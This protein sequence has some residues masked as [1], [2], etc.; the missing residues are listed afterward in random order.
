M[1]LEALQPTPNV[2]VDKCLRN[3]IW[4]YLDQELYETAAFTAE[5][6]YAL[7]NENDSTRHLIGIIN[8]RMGRFLTTIEYTENRIHLGCLYIHALSCYKIKK[9]NIGIAALE[10]AKKL[11]DRLVYEDPIQGSKYR[12]RMPTS[13]MMYL[14]LGKLYRVVNSEKKA[15]LNFGKALNLDPLCWEASAALCEL[16]VT[17]DVTSLYT[18][19]STN[20]FDDEVK[21]TQVQVESHILAAADTNPTRSRQASKESQNSDSMDLD[22]GIQDFQTPT[23]GKKSFIDLFPDPSAPIKSKLEQK[24]DISFQDHHIVLPSPRLFEVDH[25]RKSSVE[26]STPSR[27]G[28]FLHKRLFNSSHKVESQKLVRVATKGISTNQKL[29]AYKYV[30]HLYKIFIRCYTH[31]CKYQC[32]DAVRMLSCLGAEQENTP[33]VLS[34][35]A[36]IYFEKVE[37]EKAAEYYKKLLSVDRYRQEDMEYYSTLLWHLKRDVELSYLA[38]SL[39]NYNKSSPQAWCAVGNALSLMRDNENALKAFKR[40]SSLQ[41]D[42]PY[43]YTLQAHEHVASDAHE[44]AQNCYREALNVDKRHYN[45]WYGLGMVCIRLGNYEHARLHF[46]RAS[47]INPANVVLICCIGMVH[48]KLEQFGQ[49]LEQYNK[50]ISL[51]PLSALARFKR[52]KLS[53]KMMRFDDAMYDLDKL[54]VLTPDEATV[55]FLRGQILKILGKKVAAVQE[56]TVA[57]SLDP[58]S[59]HLIKDAIENSQ[60]HNIGE[61]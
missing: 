22:I 28:G 11:Y 30:V 1:S 60:L 48:E 49:A 25:S 51:Q 50:A 33:W 39:L 59:S 15:I 12:L 35:Y 43:S 4:S 21:D 46:L 3:L 52:A 32:D 23:P 13:S 18:H 42:L 26:I 53:L 9:Y 24:N 55:H 37:Y 38:Y 57:L 45:A 56:F 5:R 7:D 6:L 44:H 17:I 14:L 19:L 2:L 54:V 8:Y 29:S 20:I 36:R 61:A 31:F 34:K 40:A 58:K 27:K 16:H 10:T 41:P 47:Q